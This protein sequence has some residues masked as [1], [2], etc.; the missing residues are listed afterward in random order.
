MAT[1]LSSAASR[2]ASGTLRNVRVDEAEFKSWQNVDE[3]QITDADIL[4]RYRRLYVALEYYSQGLTLANV[5][6]HAKLGKRR[7]Y[8]LL[9]K[10]RSAAPDGQPWGMRALVERSCIR[11]PVRTSSRKADPDQ[12]ETAGYGGLF[13]RLLREHPGIEKD[14]IAKLRRKGEHRLAPNTLNFHHLHRMFI[15]ICGEHGLGED[16]YPLSTRS[17]GRAPLR[18]WLRTDFMQ[19]H[20]VAW[21][22]AEIGPDA[23]QA[24]S[25]GQGSGQ[26]TALVPV[27]KAWQIDEQTVNVLARYDMISESGDVESLDT[28]R[29]QVIRVVEVRG[30]ANLAWSMVIARQVGAHDLIAV[31]WDAVNGQ[32]PARPVVQ[33]LSYQPGGGFPAKVIPELHFALPSV[34]YLDN[35]LAHLAEALQRMVL[36]LWGATVRLGRP[37]VPQERAKVESD[38]KVMTEQLLHQMPAATGS[39]PRS[40]LRKRANRAVKQRVDC[41]E[42]AHTI[43][44]YLA[45]KNVSPSAAC[46]YDTPFHWIRRQ[47]EAGRLQP[48]YLPVAKRFAHLFYPPTI[49]AVRADMDRGRRP[50]VNFLGARYSSDVLARSFHLIGNK[51]AIRVDPRDL[52]I[53]HLYEIG[54]GHQWGPLQALGRWGAFPHDLRIRKMYLLFKR[55]AEFSEGPA[56]DPLERLYSHLRARASTN[57]HDAT[58]LTYLMTYLEGWTDAPQSIAAACQVWRAAQDAANDAATL[59][60]QAPTDVPPAQRPG[61]GQDGLAPAQPVAAPAEPPSTGRIVAF[62]PIARRRVTA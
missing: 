5:V 50:F 48:V 18:R 44:T 25:Y 27:Y 45:N 3:S 35:A 19:R 55:Q 17:Q 2:S 10:C 26:D 46:H 21:L 13:R 34:I 60:L 54:T 33:G 56:D 29:Y 8:T 51:F 36:E 28:E 41:A 43:D 39:S 57:R 7:F 38:I 37:G 59:T 1:P 58:R 62:S 47:L 9:A 15:K 40:T 20:A 16:D 22:G 32:E 42:L 53:V 11:T 31:L 52:R 4:T 12:K 6:A 61:E 23:A 14:L 30:G 24:A 49:G